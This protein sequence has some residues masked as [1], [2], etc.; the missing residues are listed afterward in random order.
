MKKK[1]EKVV[2]QESRKEAKIP[3]SGNLGLLALG[4]VGMKLWR[5]ARDKI[6]KERKQKE[7]NKKEVNKK[8]KNG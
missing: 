4:S 7:S 6:E 2:A 5:E 8:L 3:E 1:K